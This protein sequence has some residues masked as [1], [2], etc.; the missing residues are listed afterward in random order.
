MTTGPHISIKAE[1]L[2]NIAG[3]H[4]TNSLFSSIIVTILFLLLALNYSTEVQKER[5]NG[6][7]YFTHFIL[8]Q[9]YNLFNSVVGSK[10]SVFF[11]WL[12]AFFLYI[13]FENWFGLLPGAGSILLRVKEAEGFGYAPLLRANTADL[14]TTLVLGIV[15]IVLVQYYGIKYVGF[16]GYIKK[17]INF[18]GPM[19]FILGI[20]EIV[21]EIS[22]IIS[23]SFRLYGN[24]FAGEVL[25][26]I[27]SFLVP[28]LASFPF[29]VMEIFVGL[30]QALV[31]SML[32]SVFF[33]LA[34]VK[35]H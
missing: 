21:S 22:R 34:T 33:D 12:G 29:L 25:L 2:F 28:V 23:F 10:I 8:L 35:H 7:F 9:I 20:L 6:L 11:P 32:T 27:I 19:A 30:I 17:Y 26:V 31:F 16:T 14:N 13:L 5:K 4:I 18:S 3:F 15:A 1:P 24:I